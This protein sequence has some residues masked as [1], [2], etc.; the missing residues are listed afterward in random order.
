M[1][2]VK[3]ADDLKRVADEILTETDL[4]NIFSD[5]GTV[6]F[7]GSYRLN[8]MCQPDIDLS[9]NADKP[10]LKN[11]QKI[12]HKLIDSGKF[13]S[14][15]FTDM[16]NYD[17]PGKSKGFYWKLI[18]EKNGTEWKI[19]IWYSTKEEDFTR[20][21]T[22]KF[23]KLLKENPQKREIILKFK[24]YLKSGNY[25][26]KYGMSGSAIYDAVLNKKMTSIEDYEK[27]LLKQF[28]QW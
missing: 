11:A 7:V 15:A 19:D 6:H 5:I 2:V 23:E 27:E 13:R 24:D 26:Y 16:Y 21:S 22:E 28:G 17:L 8:V 9:V 20:E 25:Q 4:I 12:T 18:T 3:K 14:V 10:S 1:S